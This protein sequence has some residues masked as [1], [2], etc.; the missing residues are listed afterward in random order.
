MP[1][2]VLEIIHWIF[3][4]LFLTTS[5]N[6]LVLGTGLLSSKLTIFNYFSSFKSVLSYS[7]CPLSI[8]IFLKLVSAIL[9][10]S[11]FFLKPSFT[12]NIHPSR[13]FPFGNKK[14]VL[15]VCESVS[16]LQI[17]SFVSYFRFHI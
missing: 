1:C 10:S 13:P 6:T 9:K 3:L 8:L 15:Y 2:I 4:N 5:K 17:S 12:L 16:V 14:S 7:G 11:T